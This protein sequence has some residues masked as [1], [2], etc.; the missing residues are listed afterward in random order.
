M[1]IF[2]KEPPWYTA[3]LAFECTGC[4]ECCAGPEEGYVWVTDEEIVSIADVLD[5]S[6]AEVRRRYVRS[7]GRR[8]SL[9]ERK[10]NRDCV[11]LQPDGE[12]GRN[13]RIYNARPTQCR[14]WPFWP[15]NMQSPRAWALAGM[16]CPGINRGSRLFT[17]EEIDAGSRSTHE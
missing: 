10:G 12:G 1:K 9:V 13:C 16:R 7:V 14:T 8:H 2:H 5:V 6:Q 17:L 4:G 11:F 3:G 15:L